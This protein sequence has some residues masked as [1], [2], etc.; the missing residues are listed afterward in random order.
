MTLVV[1]FIAA[2]K[3]SI[4]RVYFQWVNEKQKALMCNSM[5]MLYYQAPL[6][7]FF[8][9]CIIPFF[10][11]VFAAGGIFGTTWSLPAVVCILMQ[12]HFM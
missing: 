8:V 1:N 7:A 6:S 2:H 9:A 12:S 10:E 11:P 3:F 5:Q 4:L